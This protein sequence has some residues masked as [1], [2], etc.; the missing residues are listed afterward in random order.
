MLRQTGASTFDKIT[1]TAIGAG[2]HAIW[3][4]AAAM[5]PDPYNTPLAVSV[6]SGVSTQ[7]CI[8]ALEFPGATWAIGHF[9][10]RMPKSWNE[11]TLTFVPVWTHPAAVSPY[12]V[13][14]GLNAL[15]FGDLEGLAQTFTSVVYSV[16]SGGVTNRLNIGPES[17]ALTV[18]GTPG[19]GDLVQFRVFRVIDHASDTMVAAARLL[20]INVFYTTDANTDA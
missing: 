10:I 1:D 7:P 13:V 5:F 15:A 9:G 17:S 11:G 4:P 19:A 6:D 2:K 18:E 8:R 14:W 16:D 3:V 12:G 20:G